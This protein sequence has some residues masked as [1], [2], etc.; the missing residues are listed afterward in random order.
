MYIE[1]L[2]K[3][4]LHEPESFW[5]NT[6]GND[7]IYRYIKEANPKMREEFD[8]LVSGGVI[9]KPIK[10]TIT[11][12]E[13]DQ[14]NNVYSFLLF[15]GYLKAIK[16]VDNEKRMYRL[17]IPN[18]EIKQ[19]Y[20]SIFSEWFNEQVE[21]NGTSFVEALRKEQIRNATEILNNVLFQSISYFDYD[22]KFY[23]GLLL[24]MLNDY[25][26]DRGLILELKIAASMA[27]VRS[28]AQ[29][30][31]EQIRQKKYMEGLLANGYEDVIGYGIAFY[32]KSCVITK[33]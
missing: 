2:N 18:K 26:M 23:H 11:Y 30:A 13:M 20:V 25:I 33:V 12:R 5:A 27:E 29:K 6:S 7:I 17:S 31:C 28:M 8:I 3:T 24:G 9:E 1:K 21:H 4:H 19:I 22:E 15:T 16:C 14:I 32:K 10:D